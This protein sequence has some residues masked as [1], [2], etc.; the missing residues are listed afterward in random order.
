MDRKYLEIAEKYGAKAASYLMEKNGLGVDD[1]NLTPEERNNIEVA[2][3]IREG[4][5]FDYKDIASR[6]GDDVARRM[7]YNFRHD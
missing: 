3:L 1:S 5:E 6:F 7:S 4:V 2:N